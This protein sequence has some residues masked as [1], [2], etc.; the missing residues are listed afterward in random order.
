METKTIYCLYQ[1]KMTLFFTLLD[2]LYFSTVFFVDVNIFHA[3]FLVD[4]CSREKLLRVII[5][6]YGKFTSKC[7]IHIYRL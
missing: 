3:N 5:R 4:I 7:V 1:V 2:I 6:S